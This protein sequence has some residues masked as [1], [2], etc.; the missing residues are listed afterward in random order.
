MTAA[1]LGLDTAPRRRGWH[2]L[3]LV[4]PLAALWV[5]LNLAFPVIWASGALMVATRITVHVMIALGL[6]LG[7]ERT[8]LTSSQRRNVWLAVMVPVTLWLAIIWSA[9]TGGAF[10][11]GAASL[12]LL[13][14]ATFVPML[15]GLPILLRSRRIGEVLDAMPAS[16]ILPLQLVRLSGFTFFVAW[17]HGKMPGAFALQAGI[18][19]IL[20]ALLAVPI[21]ISLAS[22]SRASRRAAVAWNVFGILDFAIAES[23]GLAMTFGLFETGFQSPTSGLYPAVMIPAFGVPTDII[24]HALSLRQL[25]RRDRA[26]TQ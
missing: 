25:A 22:G 5:A 17:V 6:W 2:A 9:A 1:T 15:L 4:V 8:A 14:I 13:P 21:A 18:C 10:R 16:W 20:V 11:P 23:I 26:V 3:F 19:D 7:L 12:P 24:L